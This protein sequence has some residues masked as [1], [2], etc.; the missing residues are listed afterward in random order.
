MYENC[1][2]FCYE[3]N[4]KGVVA[5]TLHK[6]MKRILYHMTTNAGLVFH[7]M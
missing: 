2:K 1:T 4:S 7:H 3:L 6:V 5:G